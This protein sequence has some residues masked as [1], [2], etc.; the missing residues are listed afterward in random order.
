MPKIMK[1]KK[2]NT[3]ECEVRRYLTVEV[4]FIEK[5]LPKE[6]YEGPVI[7]PDFK[8]KMEADWKRKLGADSVTIK[9]VKDFL[10]E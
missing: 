10:G 5:G 7:D 9:K 4:E 1:P 8:K 2:R 3:N 6:D